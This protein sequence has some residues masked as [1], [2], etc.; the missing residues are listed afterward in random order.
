MGK[1]NNKAAWEQIK[2]EGNYI[3]VSPVNSCNG[4][5]ML[6]SLEFGILKSRY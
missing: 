5:A 1:N 4:F 2:K 6:F 3:H